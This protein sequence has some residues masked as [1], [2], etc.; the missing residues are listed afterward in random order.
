M[1]R[2]KRIPYSTGSLWIA[3]VIGGPFAAAWLARRNR[4]STLGGGRKQVALEAILWISGVIVIWISLITPP[5]PISQLLR[6]G[7]FGYLCVGLWLVLSR[8]TS[9]SSDAVNQR[10]A[11]TWHAIAVGLIT[12]CAM[13]GCATR[14]PLITLSAHNAYANW[15]RAH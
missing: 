11:P 1:K 9:V 5:D 15:I 6:A 14:I 7:L 2:Q 12:N 10:R 3:T 8:S 13:F 4:L